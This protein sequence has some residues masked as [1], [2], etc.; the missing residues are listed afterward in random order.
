[1]NSAELAKRQERAVS[2]AL[3]IQRVEEGFRVYAAGEPKH[4]YIVSGSPNV[5]QCTCPDF[6]YHRSDPNWHC[7]HILAVLNE[8]SDIVV[9]ATDPIEAEERRA[10]QEEA[11]TPR[12]RKAASASSNGGNGTAQMLLKRSVS[13]DG[14]IDALSVEF[15]TPLDNQPAE[16]IRTRASEMLQLQADIVSQFLERRIQSNGDTNGTPAPPNGQ[17]ASQQPAD[18]GTK[19]PAV[20]PAVPARMVGIGGMDGKWG[21]RL[22]ISI[23]VNGKTMR[24]FGNRKQLGD[25]II[26]AGFP[27]AA[28][29]IAEGVQLNLPCRVTTSASSVGR[30]SDIDQV[31]PLDLPQPQRTVRR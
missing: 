11:R 21:R 10:I 24:L 4:R 30:F 18:S 1:M 7:K 2:E 29:N 22:F 14:R 13:P 6:Q 26:K 23:S 20:S 31:L 16:A 17:P 25:F 9:P 12:K 8:F 19:S 15:S 5:A 3:V 27:D 28:Q